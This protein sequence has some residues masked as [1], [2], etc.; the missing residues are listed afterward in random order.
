MLTLPNAASML[1]D[2]SPATGSPPPAP[3]IP[4]GR[5][6]YAVSVTLLVVLRVYMVAVAAVVAFRMIGF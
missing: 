3:Q 5:L 4:G 1:R 6:M 2:Q